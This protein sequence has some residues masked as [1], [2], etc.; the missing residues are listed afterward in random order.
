MNRERR[1]VARLY[2]I[3][4]LVSDAIGTDNDGAESADNRTTVIK[5]GG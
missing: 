2:R 4:T 1:R 5:G 3:K